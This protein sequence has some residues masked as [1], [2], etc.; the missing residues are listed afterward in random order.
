M[1]DIRFDGT[2]NVLEIFN[3]SQYPGEINAPVKLDVEHK[4]YNKVFTDLGLNVLKPI[5]D[6]EDFIYVYVGT[7]IAK[8]ELYSFDSLIGRSFGDVYPYFKEYFFPVFREVLNTGDRRDILTYF[9]EGK[10][11]KIGIE[12]KVLLKRFSF[13]WKIK[14]KCMS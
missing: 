1:F 7:S 2:D 5:N 11:L 4:K 12:L 14:L 10:D 6:G 9:Y 13:S 8:N 3:V